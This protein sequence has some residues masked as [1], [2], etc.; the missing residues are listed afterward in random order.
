LVNEESE[1]FRL[2]V[3]NVDAHLYCS[4]N[5]KWVNPPWLI[6]RAKDLDRPLGTPTENAFRQLR[7]GA[8]VRAEKKDAEWVLKFIRVGGLR[9]GC[10]ENWMQRYT[11]LVEQPGYMR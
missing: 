3:A 7:A 5:R 11:G 8:V 1:V 10:F 6:P 4:S 2:L 9:S